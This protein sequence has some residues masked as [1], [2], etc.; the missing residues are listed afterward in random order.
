[1]QKFKR[2]D[3]VKFIGFYCKKQKYCEFCKN[4]LCN[5]IGIVSYSYDVSD[6]YEVIFSCFEYKSQIIHQ[7]EIV[8]FE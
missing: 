8:K 3:I 5:S 2:G 7:D 1:M 6:T 4:Q